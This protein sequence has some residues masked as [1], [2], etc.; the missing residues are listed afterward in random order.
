LQTGI[1]PVLFLATV[2]ATEGADV[3]AVVGIGVLTDIMGEL[4]M[5]C[6]AFAI[7]LEPVFTWFTY[8]AIIVGDDALKRAAADA[9]AFSVPGTWAVIATLNC[10]RVVIELFTAQPGLKALVVES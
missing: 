10:L 7:L 6:V 8:C 9:F 5:T 4:R 2:G 1:T 3:G